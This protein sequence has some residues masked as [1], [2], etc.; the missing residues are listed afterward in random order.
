M[1]QKAEQ[2][3]NIATDY[4]DKK[5]TAETQRHGE[6]PQIKNATD[7]TDYTDRNVGAQGAVPFF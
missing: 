5:S 6:K 7:Y 3:K 1:R 2:E 4:T